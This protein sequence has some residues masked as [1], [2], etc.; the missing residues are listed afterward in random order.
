MCIRDSHS[1]A[2]L[3]RVVR[4]R[5]GTI[6]SPSKIDKD[7]D[8]LEEFYGKDGYIETRVNML[9]KPN[10]VTGNIDIEYQVDEG[11]RYNVES[12]EIEGNTKTKSTVI[13]RELVLGLSLIHISRK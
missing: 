6:F 3:R 7:K 4:E 9:R 13:L 5:T 2:L 8:R 1:S 12:I 10:I 11:D